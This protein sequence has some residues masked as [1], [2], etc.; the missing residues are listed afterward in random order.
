MKGTYL[1][2]YSYRNWD[3]TSALRKAESALFSK[4]EKK[5]IYIYIKVEKIYN[6]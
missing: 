6:A 1:R 3:K 4:K 5:N 2:K